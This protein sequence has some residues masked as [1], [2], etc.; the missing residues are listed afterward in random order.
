MP[1]DSQQRR[2]Q[3]Q[4]QN[5][6]YSRARTRDSVRCDRAVL[7]YALRAFRRYIWVPLTLRVTGL[8]RDASA[9]D[10]RLP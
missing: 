2:Q 9:S 10:T 8:T 1:L 3:R 4:Q 6:A 7:F 5:A